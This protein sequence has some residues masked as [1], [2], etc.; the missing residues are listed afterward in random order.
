MIGSS[1]TL[2]KRCAATVA[3][4]IAVVTGSYTPTAAAHSGGVS[5]IDLLPS[6]DGWRAR[7]DLPLPDA[8]V[9]L[10]LDANG[11][12]VLR[13]GEIVA[14]RPLIHTRLEKR[15][16]MRAGSSGGCGLRDSAA[17]E[18]VRRLSGAHLRIE[19]RYACAT[20]EDSAWELDAGRWLEEVP[21]HGLLVRIANSANPVSM[22]TSSSTSAMLDGAAQA[23]RWGTARRFFV[24]GIEH[25]IT[26]YDHLAFLA[27]LMIG[28]LRIAGNDARRILLST[29]GIVTAFT[30]SHSVTLAL[31]ALELVRLPTRWVEVAIAA[32]ILVTAVAM[33]LRRSWSP[34]WRVASTVG[35]IHGL[36]FASLL[37]DL[38]DGRA[39]ALPLAAFNL[40]LEAAQLGLVLATL[41]VLLHLARWPAW[42]ARVAPMFTILL[43]AGGGLWLWERV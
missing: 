17:P 27:L 42:S 4:A 34:D 9:E 32:S 8:A 43:A 20:P 10:E 5:Y 2:A 15:L 3:V 30:V 11:D 41:P 33:L 7:I 38:L 37:G 22:L 21:D 40:G 29:A 13:W 28:V 1:R 19:L 25:L 39:T 31:A 24:L 14:A 16:R 6:T 12:G 35:L 18:L 26:G 23:G 36:G